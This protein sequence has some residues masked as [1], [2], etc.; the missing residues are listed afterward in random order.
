MTIKIIIT[1]QKIKP[2][3][4]MLPGHSGLFC[5][6]YEYFFSMRESMLFAGLYNIEESNLFFLKV[7]T[8]VTPC[9]IIDGHRLFNSINHKSGILVHIRS[10]I[11]NIIH[12][13][14][15][16]LISVVCVVPFD[17]IILSYFKTNYNRQITQR[18]MIKTVQ[19]YTTKTP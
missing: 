2:G 17:T 9:A 8:H 3:A 6:R 18:I 11:N 1:I 7:L 14:C 13:H 10:L 4:E 12:S 15:S 5:Q 19:N 16:Y